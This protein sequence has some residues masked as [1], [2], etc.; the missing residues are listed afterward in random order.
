MLSYINK[1]R[2]SAFRNM[3]WPIK[4]HELVKFIPMTVL[5]FVI[6]LNQN[7]VRSL[8]DS[9]V[10]VSIGSEVIS[11]IK[12][13]IEGPFGLAVVALY[14]W[15][16]NRFTTE[17]VFRG[18]VLSFLIFFAIFAYALYPNADLI[19]PDVV[20]VEQLAMHHPHFKWFIR[21][22]GK[23]SFVLFYVIGEIWPVLVFCILYWQLANK[24]TKTQEA[25]RFYP[26]FILFGQSNLLIS[27][28]VM[29][30][31]HS[32]SHIFKA[33]FPNCFGTELTIKSLTL[34]MLISGAMILALHLFIDHK[35]VRKNAVKS[36]PKI[37]KLSF[38]SSM[39]MLVKS[40]YLRL[41]CMLII[42]YAMCINLVEGIWMSKISAV[43]SNIQDIV[44]Y[45]G[46]VFFYTGAFTLV[47]S[48]FGSAIIRKFGWLSSAI[49]NPLMIMLA[50]MLFF[51]CCIMEDN[52]KYVL[53][54]S[55][56]I[57]VYLTV[58]VG[59]LWH[60]MG[61]GTKYSLFDATK[62]MLFIPLDNESKTKGKAAVE[63][64]G[65]KIGKSAGAVIQF[66]IFTTFPNLQYSDI[67]IPLCACFVII[68]AVWIYSVIKLSDQYNELQHE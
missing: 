47:C 25:K 43:Y 2:N 57:P 6:L 20:Y 61:K 10:M 65:V 34:V 5:M 48:F 27:G 45:N 46:K 53:Y 62:E 29:M 31:F 24:V 22:W 35:I 4:S 63:I 19:H 17:S 36:D 7:I 49:I 26:F 11:F 32:D 66:M 44:D 13:W 55:Q 41:T 23:W 39:R 38:F 68:C 14:S 37:L 54:N 21:L 1:F 59:G 18:I 67:A 12:L 9:L 28:S 3:I 33:F 30:Y 8:K 56:F 15:L 51:A 60:V 40:R 58:I 42:S 16:C 52:L 50:G 64:V